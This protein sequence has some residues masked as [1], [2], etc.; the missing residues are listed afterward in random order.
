MPDSLHELKRR[1]LSAIFFVR[2]LLIFRRVEMKGV[3]ILAG[4]EY[5]NPN[6]TTLNFSSFKYA[7]R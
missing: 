2:I 6:T 3:V 1:L 5:S 4:A 7:C